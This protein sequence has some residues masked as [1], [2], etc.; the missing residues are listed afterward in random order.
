MR[1]AVALLDARK[2]DFEYDGEISPDV[3]L[4]PSIRALYPF[5]RLTGGRQRAG[6]AGAALGAHHLAAD[7]AAGRRHDDRAAADRAW[8]SRCRSCRWMPRSVRS[9]TS[10]AWRRI[11]RRRGRVGGQTQRSTAQAAE[12]KEGQGLRP[13][14]PPEGA[15]LWTPAKGGALGTHPLV[16]VWQGGEWATAYTVR[17]DGP[18][19]PLPIPRPA[20]PQPMDGVQRLRLWWGSRGQRPSRVSGRSPDLLPCRPLRFGLRRGSRLCRLPP[21]ATTERR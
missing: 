15:A 18:C 13:W 11:R 2:V 6:D 10:R 3:A 20:T 17:R 12:P 14:T 4:E 1:D 9:W 16:G 5:C 21:A 7:A 19:R 8:S